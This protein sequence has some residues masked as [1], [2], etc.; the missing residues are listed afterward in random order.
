M[1]FAATGLV[2]ALGTASAQTPDL[3]TDRPDQTASAAAM[4]RGLVQVETGYLFARKDRVDTFEVPG[5]L[6]RSGRSR[7]PPTWRS[8]SAAMAS[9]TSRFPTRWASNGRCG[10]A[11]PCST[12]SFYN[13]RKTSVRFGLGGFGAG[14]GGGRVEIS[15]RFSVEPG[16]EINRITLLA[17]RFP[18]LENRAFIVKLNRL[19]RF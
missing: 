14:F 15:Q 3:V 4:P 7:S 10:A 2:V 6:V 9:R 11:W 18:L 17:T 19:F 1:L 8:R 12:G 16:L 5:T 13:G